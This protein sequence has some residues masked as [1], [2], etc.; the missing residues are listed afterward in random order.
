M[1]SLQIIF[2]SHQVGEAS[3]EELQRYVDILKKKDIK[4]IDTAKAYGDS[5]KRLGDIEAS[6]AFVINTQSPS[7]IPKALSRD[8]LAAGIDESLALLKTNKVDV[9]HLHTPD[10]QTP[11]EETVDTIQELHRQ[12]KF[13]RFGLSNYLPEDV[14]KI[15]AYAKSTGGIVPTVY[16]GNYNAFARS[17]EQD[18]FPVLREL[19]LSF[20]AYSPVAGGLFAKDP[21]KLATSTEAGRFDASHIGGVVYNA[22]YN[23]PSV[24]EALRQWQAIA[25]DIG[26]TSI[27][28]AYRWILFHS[29]L[30]AQKG[31]A[32][33]VGASRPAQLEQTLEL[34]SASKPLE[35]GVVEK[36]DVLWKLVEAEAPRDNYNSWAK[37]NL[38]PEALAAVF[39]K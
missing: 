9:Y 11:I 1:C 20:H 26:D 14:R 2:G 3:D 22:L 6:K 37:E 23:K 4:T 12:G 28:L 29:K 32:V 25:K 31:D 36:I 5:E 33:I 13:E 10:D 15:H 16:Q 19:G 17:I 35:Q 27:G 21:E 39:D 8:I 24:V 30:D 38:T 34:L 18:L 7:I